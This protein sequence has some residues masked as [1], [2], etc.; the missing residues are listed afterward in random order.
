MAVPI[1]GDHWIAVQTHLQ[2][3]C[4]NERPIFPLFS[5]VTLP[6]H[7]TGS[8]FTY[9]L[10]SLKKTPAGHASG[11]IPQGK[12]RSPCVNFLA[13]RHVFFH[14]GNR[15]A[16]VAVTNPSLKK[17]WFFLKENSAVPYTGIII[18]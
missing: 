3:L 4:Q 8:D 14:I 17:A 1:T 9:P 11:G 13:F 6:P 12:A 7:H 18:A 15:H 16:K 2:I 10:S 5:T